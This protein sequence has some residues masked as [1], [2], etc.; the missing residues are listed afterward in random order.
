MLFR[1]GGGPDGVNDAGG[2]VGDGQDYG[3]LAGVLP[4]DGLQAEG[5]GEPLAQVVG[6]VYQ[7]SGCVR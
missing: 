4:V 5:G 1:S 6:C 2:G 7:E 3:G